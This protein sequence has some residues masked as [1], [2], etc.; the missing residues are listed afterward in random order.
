VLKIEQAYQ[1]GWEIVLELFKSVDI[2]YQC[3]ETR[4]SNSNRIAIV[5]A[6][7]KMT[8]QMPAGL[9][10]DATSTAHRNWCL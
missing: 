10:Y 6:I 5:S 3:F 9:T 7:A 8:A 4:E 2:A 1:T